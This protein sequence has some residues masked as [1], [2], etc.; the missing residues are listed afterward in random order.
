[1]AAYNKFET[2][3]KDLGEG[4]HQLHA[5]GHTCNIYLSNATPSAS[6]DNVKAD[7]AEISTGNGYTGPVDIVNTYTEAS[8]TGTFGGTDV[9]ITA[10]GGTVGP[11]RYAVLYND[12]P[13]SPADPLI[14]WWDYGTAVTLN[15]GESFTVDFGASIFTL[16]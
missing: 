9:T 4:T 2:F 13:T 1:M 11:F 5:A 3:V 16:A 8:G 14:A 7:L 6:A 15:D 10:S 12:D